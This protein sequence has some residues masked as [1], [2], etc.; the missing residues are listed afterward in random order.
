MIILK[1]SQVNFM[2]LKHSNRIIKIRFQYGSYNVSD[3]NQ[4]NNDA[5]QEKF[6]ITEQPITISVDVNRKLGITT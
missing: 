6:N 2:S 1:T 4:I 5:I 3:I